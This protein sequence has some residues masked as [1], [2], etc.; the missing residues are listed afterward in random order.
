M[1]QI[2]TQ[3][4]PQG[5]SRIKR[6]SPLVISQI[7]AG[8][9]IDRPAAV[10]KELLENAIDAGAKRVVVQVWQGGMNRIDVTDDGVGIHADD[11]YLSVMRH[12]TSKLAT[13]DVLGGVNTLGFRGEAL[14]S[15][16]AVARLEIASSAD[17]TGIGRAFAVAGASLPETSLPEVAGG[18]VLP[19]HFSEN[20]Q[21]T[22]VN[23][24]QIQQ[25]IQESVQEQAQ[26]QTHSKLKPVAMGR[27]THVSVQALFFNVPARRRFLKSTATEFGHVEAVVRRL[28]LNYFDISFELWHQ[29]QLRLA[30]NAIPSHLAV[31]PIHAQSGH[32]QPL[33]T[34]QKKRLAVLL[35]TDFAASAVPI[36]AHFEDNSE[37]NGMATSYQGQLTGW[38]GLSHH[39][40]DSV[41]KSKSKKLAA[42][43]QYWFVNGRLVQNRALKILVQ[44]SI[45]QAITSYCTQ[46]D[47]LDL[48][49]VAESMCIATLSD[50]ILDYVLFLQVPEGTVNV[51]IHPTKLDVRLENEQQVVSLVGYFLQKHIRSI[52]AGI[53][54]SALDAASAAAQVPAKGLGSAVFWNK[55]QLLS[56]T[57]TGFL[58]LNAKKGLGIGS[59]TEAKALL[60]TWQT[61]GKPADVS[62]TEVPFDELVTLIQES[63]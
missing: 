33:E 38:L 61:H 5:Q 12:A 56:Q 45:S 59:Q 7:A 15:I 21:Q 26:E 46:P 23:Q 31:Q 57:E 16:A 43:H 2:D 35:D 63:L 3:P 27:G 55:H 53:A 14:A 13:E 54:P 60:N 48:K 36:Q 22:S 9:V 42:K 17:D 49:D 47:L 6:L 24:Q 62:I 41:A 18:E 58:L 44:Q 32:N 19:P 4:S 29:D 39:L 34:A 8:E 11:L 10:V 20:Q 52:L 50:V 30:V 1:S 37:A 40:H 51:N 25:Q 28:A